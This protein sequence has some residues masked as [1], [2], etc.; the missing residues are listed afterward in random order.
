MAASSGNPFSRSLAF[1]RE[2]R[3][4]LKKVSWPSRETTIKY[5]VIVIIGS[6]TVGL[7]VGGIDYLLTLAIDA[8]I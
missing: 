5:T 3:D 6:L 7:L 4:E 8:V 2:S 1:V